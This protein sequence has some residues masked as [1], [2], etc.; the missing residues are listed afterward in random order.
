MCRLAR[1]ERRYA[2]ERVDGCDRAR[3]AATAADRVRGIVKLKLG[4]GCGHRK[5]EHGLVVDR[6]HWA[7]LVIG[8]VRVVLARVFGERQGDIL[9]RGTQAH[10]RTAAEQR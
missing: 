1:R 8:L 9:G 2:K 5:P 4:R 3:L 6:Y 7:V 10:G